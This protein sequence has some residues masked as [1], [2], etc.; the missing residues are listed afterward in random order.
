MSNESFVIEPQ[1][2]KKFSNMVWIVIGAIFLVFLCASLVLCGGIYYYTY[3]RVPGLGLPTTQPEPT[4]DIV[5]E[6]SADPAWRLALDERFSSNLNDWSVNP[7]H[8]DSLNLERRIEGGKYIWDFQAKEGWYYWDFPDSKPRGDIVVAVEVK[9]TRGSSQDGYGIILRDSR[10]ARYIF[11]INEYGRFQFLRDQDD[12][13]TT[14]IEGRR[15]TAYQPGGVNRIAVKA[16]GSHFTLYVNDRQ[17]AEVDDEALS[18]GRVGILT[19]PSGQPSDDSNGQDTTPAPQ[20]GYPSSYEFDNFQVWIPTGAKEVE[21]L[22]PLTP[23]VG[24]IVY[25]SDKDGNPEIYS[26]DSDGKNERRLTN[27]PADDYNPRWSRDGY[28][29]VFVSE[30]DGNPEIYTMWAGGSDITRITNDPASDVEPDWSPDGNKIVFISNRDGNNELY[31]YDLE[32]KTTERLTT[33][34]N[35]DHKPDWSSDGKTIL[36]TSERS[37]KYDI[38]ALDLATGRTRRLTYFKSQEQAAPRWSHD[39]SKFTY[40]SHEYAGRDDIIIREYHNS[41]FTRLTNILATNIFPA[42]SPSGDQVLFVSNRDGQVDIYILSS[43][44]KSIFRLTEDDA[45]ESDLDWTSD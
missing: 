9:H 27:N 14:L 24:H 45:E 15:A 17:V 6:I 41:D 33:N 12:E 39:G 20:D 10:T 2:E 44:G 11:E 3:R 4:V 37:G 36:Y 31:I 5:E 43:D 40:A 30:R 29:I 7:Y 22:P 1:P 25:V 8:S 42:F 32:A 26:V 28:Q 38:F 34:N 35:N 16:E 13:Y 18:S 23:E 19:A 21:A